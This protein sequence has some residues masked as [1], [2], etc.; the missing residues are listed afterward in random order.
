MPRVRALRPHARVEGLGVYKVGEVYTESEGYAEE[1]Y[2]RGFIEYEDGEPRVRA[3]PDPDMYSTRS[4]SVP[5]EV[6]ER[7][8]PQSADGSITL[9]GRNGNWYEFS[10]GE[11]VLGKRAAAEH[12]GVSIEELEVMDGDTTEE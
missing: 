11:K 2:R 8:A 3:K 10:D 7:A 5:A 6:G 1:K 9:T 12:L 4:F